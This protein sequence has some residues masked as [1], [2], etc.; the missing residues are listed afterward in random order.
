M[1]TVNKTAIRGIREMYLPYVLSDSTGLRDSPRENLDPQRKR[2]FP[3]L[4]P[5]GMSRSYQ[6]IETI[7]YHYIR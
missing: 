7:T 4:L 6:E 5:P 2:P 3:S 1:P